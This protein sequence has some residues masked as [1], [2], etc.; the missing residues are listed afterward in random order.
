MG[1][2]VSQGW[3][4]TGLTWEKGGDAGHPFTVYSLDPSGSSFTLYE[5]DDGGSRNMYSIAAKEFVPPPPSVDLSLDNPSFEEGTAPFAGAP[6]WTIATGPGLNEFYTTAGAG[7]SGGDPDSG[8]EGSG[9]Q[10]LTGNRLAL[11]PDDPSNPATSLATQGIDISAFGSEIDAGGVT[12]SLDFYYNKFDVNESGSVSVEFFDAG[13]ASLGSLNTGLLATTSGDVWVPVILEGAVPL[14]ARSLEL[15]LNAS[16][17]S[18]TG[19]NV[20]FDNFSATL[21]GV[22]G[23]I[24]EPSTFII[25]SLGLLGLAW[26]GRRRRRKA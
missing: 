5:Q 6:G 20:S 12:L 10:F 13:N 4:S 15:Q 1:W 17:S 18:G 14:G 3:T 9:S 2:V 26:Y 7:L 25:W 8:Q 23:V 19:T 21:V 16:R 11:D 24:P 22:T